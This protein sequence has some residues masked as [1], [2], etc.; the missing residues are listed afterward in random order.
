MLTFA[1]GIT[2]LLAG[3]LL[4]AGVIARAIRRF[5]QDKGVKDLLASLAAAAVALLS[6]ALTQFVLSYNL[7]EPETGFFGV[8]AATAVV[9]YFS[10]FLSIPVGMGRGWA[11]SFAFNAAR[12]ARQPSAPSFVV[13]GL[14]V[15]FI[16]TSVLVIVAFVG[17]LAW[18]GHDSTIGLP[19]IS[20]ALVFPGLMLVLAAGIAAN[21]RNTNAGAALRQVGI[22][23]AGAIVVALGLFVG[24][25]AVDSL[26]LGARRLAE[27]W[28]IL[29]LFY[30]FY[31]IASLGI[32][33]ALLFYGGRMLTRTWCRVSGARF[34]WQR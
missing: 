34:R 22:W 9:S 28:N 15:S 23:F 2:G 32:A 19:G 13:R 30:P 33:G 17:R 16:A 6:G 21:L 4:C 10:S 11:C 5:R 18:H 1:V 12:A 31:L 27:M 26:P 24:A 20:V 14:V 29:I 3:V 8:T 7:L 25:V